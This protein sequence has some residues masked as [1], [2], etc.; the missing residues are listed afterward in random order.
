V[1]ID[2]STA[3]AYHR[4]TKYREDNLRGGPSPDLSRQPEQFKDIVSTRRVSLRSYL[5]SDA[6]GG[7][8]DPSGESASL[9]LACLGRLLFYTN[10]VTGVIRFQ[11]GR[12]QLLRASPSAGALY[13]TEIYLAL[14]GLPGVEPG[15]YNYVA[16]SH[17]L[18]LLWEGDQ[19]E[20]IQRACGGDPAF[21]DAHACVLMTGVHFR[22]A[23]RYKERGYRRVLLD[24][25][26]VLA[27]LTAY[28]PHEGCRAR[29]IEGFVDSEL[30]G[31]FFFDESVEATLLCA[32]LVRGGGEQECAPL[33]ASQ[34]P[35]P[36]ELS[37]ATI[38]ES[39][40]LSGSATL[41]LHRASACTESRPA[42][43]VV[44]CEPRISP[45]S[46]P[47]ES[48][49]DLDRALPGA[50]VQRRSARGFTGQPIEIE[51]LGRALGYAFGRP[52]N[53]DG[54]VRYPTRKDGLL[55]AHVVVNDVDGIDAGLYLVEGAGAALQPL[56]KGDL[57]SRLYHLALNQEIARR[58]AAV[59][60][61][62]APAREAVAAYGDRAY[63]YLHLEAGAIGEAF[64]LAAGAL[65]LG[66]C[67][68]G[69]FLDDTAAELLGIDT[70]DFVLYLVTLGRV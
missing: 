45:G 56:S 12:S 7:S 53:G 48:P 41:A 19:M 16:R 11:D 24:T 2:R 36:P 33:W 1:P 25:G 58:C 31:L 52:R 30:N 51:Q 64:Q 55:R 22:S 67:G 32:L 60:V 38:E 10:G 5:P 42:G 49:G 27:N 62:S 40:D 34:P 63:R 59:L 43:P 9:P 35:S 21:E 29:P 4:L 8:E 28:A 15:L 46:V 69:G 68:I 50:I 66:A 54:S 39:A 61:F 18:V 70:E 6:A 23:W 65:G 20:A 14:R 44:S 57:R 47:L 26:H 17:E 37:V 3:E 13:P